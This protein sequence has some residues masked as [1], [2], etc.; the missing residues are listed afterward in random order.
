MKIKDSWDYYYYYSGKASDILRQLGF[1]G[2]ALIWV[3]KVESNGG[4][5]IAPELLPVGFW[6]VV[7]LGLDFFQ[8]LLG[9]AFWGIFTKL[10]ERRQTK[11]EDNFSAPGAINWPTLAC[12]W[13]KSAAML[14]AYFV[15]LR[16]L[17]GRFA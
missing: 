7:A 11:E 15:M 1:A 17:I 2:I 6:I 12:F 16:F 13:G 3:F 9:T 14:V 8:Y 10:K 4:Y 5:G